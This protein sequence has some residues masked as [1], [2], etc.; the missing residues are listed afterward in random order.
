[1]QHTLASLIFLAGIVQLGILT[2]SA[3]V[4]FKLEWRASLRALPRLHRQLY[5]VYGGYVVLSI[6]A[7]AVISLLNAPALASGSLLARSVCA[8]AAIFWGVRLGLQ[9]VLD[10]KPHLTGFWWRA[11][12]HSLSVAFIYLVGVFAV[13]AMA[14]RSL[15]AVLLI[16]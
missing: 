3:L 2:A 16:R 6:I 14:P 7:L 9:A 13:A 5:W 1:M 8:Y 12:Y 10:V 15:T 11:G 4:P